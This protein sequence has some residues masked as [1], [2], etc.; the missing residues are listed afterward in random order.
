MK[1]HLYFSIL[2]LSLLFVNV[3]GQSRTK[4]FPTTVTYVDQLPE[5]ENLWIFLL[6]GQSNMA[7]RGFVEPQDTIANKRILTIDKAGQWI[8][9]KEP[10]HFYEPKMAGLDCGLS[11]ARHLLKDVPNNVTIAILPCAVGGS[12]IEQ[13]LNDDT[14]RGVPLLTNFKSKVAIAKKKGTIKGV[15]WHQGE[16]DANVERIPEYFENLDKLTQQ[17][18]QIIGID[19]LPIILGQLGLYAEPNK[20]RRQWKTINK[21]IYD[22]AE[23]NAYIGV[24]SSKG[25]NEKGDKVHFDGASQR[26]MGKRFA[27]EFLKTTK[28]ANTN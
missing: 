24:I 1:T 2:F 18:R 13:W 27:D 20:K 5:A 9:A 14:H 21:I 22:Y 23:K 17:F 11:F 25:L 6:T 26:E 10:L 15:L 7:G 16:S 4:N 3:N 8:Y 28:P 19:T 12:S